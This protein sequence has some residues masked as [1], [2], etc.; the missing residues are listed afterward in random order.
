MNQDQSYESLIE[1]AEF[2]L[3]ADYLRSPC[4]SVCYLVH[5][6]SKSMLAP[7]AAEL[8]ATDYRAL[9]A[10]CLPKPIERGLR[11]GSLLI[12]PHQPE[13]GLDSKH[14]VHTTDIPRYT[15][16]S[17]IDQPPFMLVHT[18]GLFEG[19]FIEARIQRA[20]RRMQQLRQGPRM[21]P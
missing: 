17:V 5:V 7:L 2:C 10:G 9:P 4:T 1:S 12:T 13:P 21:R 20:A 11:E 19:T 6:N 8:G 15:Q 3:V 16:C 18:P 14:L